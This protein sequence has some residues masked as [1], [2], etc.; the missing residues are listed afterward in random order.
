M[1][2]LFIL[3][4]PVWLALNKTMAAPDW[5]QRLKIPYLFEMANFRV[6]FFGSMPWHFGS[7]I[8]DHLS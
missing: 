5:L 1:F 3:F 6:P 7:V 2:W 8:G 4:W